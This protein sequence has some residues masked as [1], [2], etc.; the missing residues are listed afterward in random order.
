MKK[1][2]PDQNTGYDFILEFLG[3]KVLGDEYRHG[4]KTVVK[5]G[6]YF[7]LPELEARAVLADFPENFKFKRKCLSI[8]KEPERR[9]LKQRP[10]L[11]I[12]P[13]INQPKGS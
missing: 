1:P 8:R 6:E 2:I 13:A 5:K 4:E 10:K 3:N 11:N 9:E 12:G 7:K